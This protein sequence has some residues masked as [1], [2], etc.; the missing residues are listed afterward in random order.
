MEDQELVHRAEALAEQLLRAA[1]D[2]TTRSERR[3]SRRLGRFLAHAE[4]RALLFGL[5]DE[6][7]RIEAD[8][9]VDA[10]CRILQ[11]PDVRCVSVKVSALCA[12]LDVLAFDAS[13]ARIVEQL[14]KVL[15]VANAFRPRLVYLDME[16]YRDLPLTLAALRAV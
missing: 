11:R 13:V 3:R 7:L 10:V 9:R 4:G 8:A 15:R 14:R 16:E 2:G 5:A 12:N 1:L 6:V